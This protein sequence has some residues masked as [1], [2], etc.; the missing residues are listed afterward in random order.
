MIVYLVISDLDSWD[1]HHQ[2]A[3]K[4]FYE[5]VNAEEWA[6]NFEEEKRIMKS[7]PVGKEWKTGQFDENDP[8]MKKWFD[9]KYNTYAQFNHCIIQEIEIL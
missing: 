3:E 9:W 2:I 7:T 1:T 5:R 6:K 8:E 4:V